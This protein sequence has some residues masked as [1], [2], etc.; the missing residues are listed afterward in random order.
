[1]TLPGN[2]PLTKFAI[3]PKNKPIGVTTAVKS[4]NHEEIELA[5]PAEKPDG[6]ADADQSAVN[7]I[8]PF[9]ISKR[10]RGLVRKPTVSPCTSPERHPRC[11]SRTCRRR[12]SQPSRRLGKPLRQKKRSRS[13]RLGDPRSRPCGRLGWILFYGT[14][15]C[16]IWG[17]AQDW[18]TGLPSAFLTT[19]FASWRSGKGEC[20]STAD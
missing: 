6:D 10:R 16:G 2:S 14:F 15:Y 8:P 3:R 7:D 5:A 18:C 9:Q 19:P 17:A 4:R 1:V 12:G 13:R 20:H 11:R